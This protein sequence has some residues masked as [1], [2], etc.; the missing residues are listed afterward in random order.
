MNNLNKPTLQARCKAARAGVTKYFGSATQVTLRGKAWKPTDIDAALAA[1]IAD[2]DA[3]DAAKAAWRSAVTTGNASRAVAVALLA[4]LKALVLATYGDD[5]KVLGDFAF[6]VPKGHGTVT[7]AEKAAAVDK[8]KATKK[9]LGPT[10]TKQRKKAAKQAA[11]T[12]PATT[13][14]APATGST[15]KQ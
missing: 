1:A 7:A 15:P 6:E 4:A 9:L 11:A 5:P 2:G 14:A 12:S 8:T 10:G 3:T 13:P